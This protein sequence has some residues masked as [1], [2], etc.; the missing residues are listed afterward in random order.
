[1]LKRMI[2]SSI[3]LAAV[4]AVSGCGR[5]DRTAELEDSEFVAPADTA[6]ITPGT[7]LGVP[8]DTTIVIEPTP[9]P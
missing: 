9:V 3:V 5:D 4:V 7:E 2:A 6:V 1:M 8:T